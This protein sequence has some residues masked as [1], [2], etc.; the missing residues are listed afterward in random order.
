MNYDVTWLR[1]IGEG[2]SPQGD[3]LVDV[4]NYRKSDFKLEE[5]AVMERA[6]RY[7]AAAVFFE[8]RRE[9]RPA[10]PQAFIFV[11]NGGD[12]KW[13]AKVHQRLWSW[14]GVPLAYL[15]E[16]GVLRVFRCA[17]DGPEFEANKDVKFKPYRTL[18]L[19]TDVA[20]DPWWSRAR[21]HNGSLW[22][23]AAITKELLKDGASQKE[24]IEEVKQLYDSV[25]KNDAL[26]KAL[27]RKPLVDDR[28]LREARSATRKGFRKLR[29][30]RNG[31][32]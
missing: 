31:V 22:D 26:P 21:L 12:P 23:D 7:D 1:E 11:S 2:K 28:L 5:V 16:G 27:G 24:L 25:M 6:E 14:G 19:A 9:G 30:R 20:N 10:S 13:F 17:Y 29:R 3:G 18:K 4:K 32:L 8:A 15:V